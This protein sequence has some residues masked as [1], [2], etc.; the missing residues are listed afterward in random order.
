MA[1]HSPKIADINIEMHTKRVGGR[2]D[3]ERKFAESQNPK[4]ISK[5]YFESTTTHGLSRIYSA[6][7]IYIRCFW[8]VIFLVVFG[9]LVRAITMLVLK[10]TEYNVV[11]N[12]Q[13]KFY[14]G[15]QFPAITFCNG[16]PFRESEIKK[17]YPQN[18]SKSGSKEFNEEM[19]IILGQL[20]DSSLNKIGHPREIFLMKGMDGC[21]FQNENCNLTKDFLRLTSPTTGNC[22]SYKSENRIQRRAFSGAGLFA[23]LNINQFDYAKDFPSWIASAG[24]KVMVHHS[25]E[26]FPETRAIHLVPG[27]LTDIKIEKKV[28][29]RLKAPYPDKC[30]DASSTQEKLGIPLRYSI[31]MCQFVCYLDM[32]AE[33]CGCIAPLFASTLKHFY[34]AFG[35]KSTQNATNYKIAATPSQIKCTSKF[36]GMFVKGKI[37][38][39]CPPPCVEEQFKITVSSSM[40]PP[41]NRASYYLYQLQTVHFHEKI[42]INWTVQNL[43]QNILAVNIY[44]KDFTV[45]TVEQKPAYTLDD[46]ASDLG[47]QLGLWIG[48][49]IF[50]AFE[51]GTYI[52]NMIAYFL[53][54]R[55]KHA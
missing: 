54:W 18:K 33:S 36:E 13:T 21:F 30:S 31:E 26:I 16:N 51:L 47:G 35:V 11:T 53:F 8:L 22:F 29:K 4:M 3:A 48:A 15:L 23:T 39:N 50:S 17:I 32:Q 5:D 34:L 10:T 25:D 28:I 14:P 9:L 43:Y 2:V 44:Y 6:S 7:N 49:S 27:T 1:D 24:A 46:F 38:C 55:Q 45:E 20:N 40:W 52:M 42:F 19:Q 37:S 41:L 12:V